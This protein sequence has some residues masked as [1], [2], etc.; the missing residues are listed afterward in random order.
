MNGSDD[1][2]DKDNRVLHY[3]KDNRWFIIAVAWVLTLLVGGEGLL[4]LPQN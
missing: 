4:C 2:R 1:I 3:F